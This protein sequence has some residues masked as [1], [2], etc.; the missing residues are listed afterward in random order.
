MEK[1]LAF[2]FAA[3]EFLDEEICMMEEKYGKDLK[4]FTEG[5][6]RENKNSKTHHHYE[7]WA[8][9][10]ACDEINNL[11]KQNNGITEI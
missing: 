2:S 1:V 4:F 6:Y 11:I 8:S 9:Q 10:E 7:W 5:E 3:G